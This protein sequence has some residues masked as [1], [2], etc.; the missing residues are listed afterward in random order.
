MKNSVKKILSLILALTLAFSGT[1]FAVAS[2]GEAMDN[3]GIMFCTN[4]INGL[5]NAVFKGFG[6]LFPKD[7][8]S[9]ED[10]ETENFYEGN[11]NF[12]DA[13][14]ENAKWYLGFG[15]AS[16][17]PENLKDG[18]KKYYTGGYFTQ[19][20]NGVYDDQG[21]NAVA[22][23]DNSGRGTV[24]M[25]AVDG[26]GVCN[27]DVRTIRA[28]AER[29]LAEMGV[30]SDIVAINVNSTHCHTVI[31][32]QGFGLEPLIKTIFQNLFSFLPF[33]EKTRSIDSEFYEL[34]IDGASD[35]IVEAYTAM[36]AGTLYYFETEGIGR[37]ERN[38]NYMDDKYGYIFNKRYDM[39][40]YQHVIACFKFV[41]DNKN[42]APTVFANVGGH[43]TTINRE[44]KLLSADY[45]NYTEYKMNAE[46]INFMFIQ[47]AQSPISVNAGGVETKEILDEIAKEIEAD[48][49]TKDYEQAKKL[50][51]EFARIILE[52]EENA[53][54]VEP[55]LNVKMKEIRVPLEYGLMELGAV[56]G[57]LGLTVVRDKSAPAG[58][59]VITEVGY[60]EIGTDIAMLTVP[61]ELIPQLVYGNVVD[62]TQSYTGTDWNYE[63]TADIIGEGKTVL[64]MGLCNDAIG[65]IVPDNDY[66]PFIADSL[67]NTDMGEKL[68]GKPQ[69]HYE[70]MLSAGS[71]AGS[72]VMGELNALVK[73]YK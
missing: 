14:A 13:P 58:Y 24:V 40:G 12:I 22:L 62:K 31:D 45:P 38:N 71:E 19:K 23:T 1:V 21:A 56:S 65:Y 37:S 3:S 46:G 36:E 18:S 57:L 47:G 34:M 53:K 17:V 25:V 48:P 60:L 16:M 72:S 35:A 28:E 68:W 69:R 5:L 29:K 55:V 9:I 33:I 15:K 43:P 2:E 67:W 52:A 30:E 66:A 20:I 49:V 7:F 11:K 6:A 44:T 50:G 73:E 42:S 64:V 59:S 63:Y 27:A 41:P 51:Y 26:I 8:V 32:T 10:Y 39:E 61:G 54:P 70:E 4:A